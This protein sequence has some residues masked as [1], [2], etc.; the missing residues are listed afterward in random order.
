MTNEDFI[1]H[2]STDLLAMI[3]TPK[4]LIC[5]GCPVFIK[6]RDY[7]KRSCHAEIVAW[8]KREVDKEE[9]TAITQM[10]IDNDN[11]VLTKESKKENEQ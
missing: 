3:L 4:G 1:K 2:A 7:C 5:E 10:D 6:K 8:L 9:M 11:N